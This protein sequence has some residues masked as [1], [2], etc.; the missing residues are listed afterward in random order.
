MTQDA[1]LRVTIG[2]A[3]VVV[4]ILAAAWLARR[5][6]LV[7]RQNSGVLRLI[8]SLT[9]GQRQSIA[10][11]QV[12]DTWLVVGLTPGNVTPLHTLPAG[13]L[14]GA[15]PD[16]GDPGKRPDSPAFAATLAQHLGKAI[17]R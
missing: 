12:Q 2:L 10:V 9:V 11:V 3:L 16:S 14:P 13:S 6:G 8:G 5:A 15:G 1:V 17:K 7:Q 4:A